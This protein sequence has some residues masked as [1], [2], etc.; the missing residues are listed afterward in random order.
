MGSR[1]PGTNRVCSLDSEEFPFDA[2]YVRL[3]G[4][5]SLDTTLFQPYAGPFQ[6]IC[7]YLFIR[8]YHLVFSSED[9]IWK[10]I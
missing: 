6:F 1:H 9:F 2:L 10:V 5:N 4:P 8:K 3:I 7:N